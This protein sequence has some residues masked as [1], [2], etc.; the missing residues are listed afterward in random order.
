[1]GWR[2]CIN[3]VGAS[4]AA[5]TSRLHLDFGCEKFGGAR[6]FE[7]FGGDERRFQNR[8]GGFE[9]ARAGGTAWRDQSGM[10][11]FRFGDLAEDLDLI[12]QA[13]E[14]AKNFRA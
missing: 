11:D 13:R 3:C 1:L 12:R 5:R 7:N 2:N 8:G 9:I 4:G 10:P 6:A 14:L